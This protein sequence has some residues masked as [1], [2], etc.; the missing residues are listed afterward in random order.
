MALKKYK[1]RKEVKVGAVFVIALSVMV[2]GIMY[3]QGIEILKKKRI[4]YAVYERVNGL[5]AAN[6][7]TIQGMKVG[8]V[9]TLYFSPEDP[10][11]IIVEL[12]L[13]NTTYPIPKNSVASIY[14][15]DLMGSK[16]IEILPGNSS[17]LIKDGDTLMART[18]ATLGEEVN[19]QL[20]PIKHKAENLIS[21]IDTLATILQQVLNKNTQ[22]SL[23]EAI[24]HIKEAIG[25]VAHMTYNA[26]TLVTQQRSNLARI[27]TNME[28][29]SKNLERNNDK[30]T[31]ILENFSSVSDSLARLNIPATFS[32]V[33][34]AVRNLNEIIGKI[35]SGEGTI[36]LLVN[37]SSLYYEMDKAARDLN[38]LLEDIKANPK[39]YVHVSVF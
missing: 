9:K 12:Y 30:I 20:A 24:E 26:D 39:K 6:P 4:I 32:Q 15:A 2:W 37:D 10:R 36:G 25:N 31:N 1:I 27:I 13:N 28:S 19:Q 7:V 23:I 3:L 21:S 33:D 11:K 17:E 22:A 38:L 16:E 14:S 34:Q 5:V 35:K 8:Q 18:E 29:I